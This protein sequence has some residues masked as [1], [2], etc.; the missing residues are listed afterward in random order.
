MRRGCPRKKESQPKGIS[1]I[2]GASRF[3]PTV[4]VPAENEGTKKEVMTGL[5]S[6]SKDVIMAMTVILILGKAHPD[7]AWRRIKASLVTVGVI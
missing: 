6:T 4:P 1:S 5:R 2:S 7:S 3:G